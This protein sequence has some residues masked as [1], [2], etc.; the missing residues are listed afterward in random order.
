MDTPP[1]ITVNGQLLPAGT[2]SITSQDRSF[3]FGDGFFQTIAVINN[4]PYQWDFHLSQLQK[5]ASFSQILLPDALEE[6]VKAH[7]RANPITEGSLRITISRGA[8][9]NGY[10]PTARI[11]LTVIESQPLLFPKAAEEMRMY[12]SAYRRF[13][14]SYL[15]GKFKWN[16]GLNNALALMDASGHGCK[17]ALQLTHDG[18]ICE[19]ANAN[20]FWLQNNVLFTPSLESNC[21]QGST[22]EAVLRL[23]PW[24]V[25]EVL[26]PLEM[27]RRAE[28]VWLCNT[29]WLAAQVIEI[30]PT[31]MR[32]STPNTILF[33][34]LQKDRV[35][36]ANEHAAKW[37][38]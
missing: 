10:V 35:I 14:E 38:H 12:V 21:L 32:Y 34:L 30:M 24:P 31:T 27:L 28:A 7:M 16:M 29:Q 19:A 15:P 4:V 33:S 18:A 22:R 8:G 3:R 13:P 9:S 17:A 5:A 37:H 6:W 20:I 25:K 26:V 36:Y 2:A 1:T 11:P 23:S